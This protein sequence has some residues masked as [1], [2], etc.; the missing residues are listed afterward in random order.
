MKP[1][2]WKVL[3]LLACWVAVVGCA[4]HRWGRRAAPTRKIDAA[5]EPAA[6]GP[7]ATTRPVATTAPAATAGLPKLTAQ[8]PLSDYLRYAALNNPPGVE[9]AFER[10]KAAVERVPQVKALPDPR[11][12]YTY[13]IEEI[14]TRVGAQRQ[15]FTLSQ[16][17][18]WFGKLEL[19]GDA[20][21]Q[22]AKAQFQKYQNVKLRLFY[23]VKDAY[24][25]CYYVGRA[26]AITDGNLKLM[27][28]LEGVARV[29]YKAAAAGHPDVIRAQVEL[30]KL[31]DRLRSLRDLRGPLVARLN[32]ALNRP[33]DAELALPIKCTEEQ[34]SFTDKQ[35][36]T[37]MAGA[38]PELKSLDFEIEK[39]KRFI[40]LAKKNYFPDL[41]IGAK[42]IDTNASTAGRHPADD[43]KDAWAVT[44]SVNVPIWWEKYAAGVREAKARY[45]AAQR[46]KA[47]RANTLDVEVKI[48]AY[49]LRDAGRKIDLYRDTLIPK[50]SQSL[51]ATEAAY[52]AGNAS[53]ID[54]VDTERIILEFELSYER[55]LT[56]QGQ[57]LGRLEML[58][59]RDLPRE[60]P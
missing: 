23:R 42:F 11:F 24:Y 14:E 48:T 40:E 16:M 57:R 38:N 6:A 53:F 39:Q 22:A 29:R 52:R 55:A 51:K 58:I 60:K 10:W 27:K 41:T 1:F 33:V 28:R 32:E 13:F 44:A 50:A 47:D 8:S 56:D 3:P 2:V 4:P 25:E 34:V 31:A 7:A 9:A 36:L 54:L 21:A 45:R 35:L 12:S 19:R 59:G 43:G 30:G 18:P 26:I 49:H 46:A 17:F 15:S 37:W 20:A 5:R